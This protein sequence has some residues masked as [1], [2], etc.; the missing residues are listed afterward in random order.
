MTSAQSVTRARSE[1]SASRGYARKASELGIGEAIARHANPAPDKGAPITLIKPPI[2]FSKNSYSTPLTQ[3][4]GLTYLA[5]VLEKAG[6]LVRIIDCPGADPDRI[7]LS[8][9]GCFR[10]QG[11]D[12]EAAIDCIDP[13]SDIIG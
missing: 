13:R 6:Y 1:D 3:P 4:I 12:I 2:V 8:E 5:A 9:D 10:V 7:V 11:L